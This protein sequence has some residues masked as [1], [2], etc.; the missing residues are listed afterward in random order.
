M[1]E[2]PIA[3]TKEE[4]RRLARELGERIRDWEIRSKERNADFWR[5]F[6]GTYRETQ[7]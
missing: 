1:N 2:K 4:I 7:R 5:Q 6:G 3:D